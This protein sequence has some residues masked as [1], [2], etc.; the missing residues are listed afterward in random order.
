MCLPESLMNSAWASVPV[1]PEQSS[2]WEVRMII[3]KTERKTQT[4]RLEIGRAVQSVLRL[5]SLRLH[6][7]HSIVGNKATS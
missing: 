7:A 1:W 4:Q 6:I 2:E 5:N 3:R